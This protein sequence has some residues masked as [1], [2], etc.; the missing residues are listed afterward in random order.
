MASPETAQQST[1]ASNPPARLPLGHIVG[2]FVRTGRFYAQVW[3][4]YLGGESADLPVV[5]PTP[6]L[7]V[8]A[9]LD[10]VLVSVFRVFRKLPDAE[11]FERVEREV[12]T[13]LEF[14]EQRGWLENPESFFAPRRRCPRSTSAERARVNAHT[15]ASPSTANMPPIPAHR[16]PSAG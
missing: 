11:V 4:R 1:G 13:A 3:S 7:A 6:S 14:Y 12:T 16:V 10:E 15:S 5:R 8:H 2:P 9:L